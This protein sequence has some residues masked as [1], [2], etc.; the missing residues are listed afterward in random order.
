VGG[1]VPGI[2]TDHGHGAFRDTRRWD[3]FLDED[4]QQRIDGYRQTLSFSGA[5]QTTFEVG[6]DLCTLRVGGSSNGE[7]R[8]IVA[9]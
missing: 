7:H 3:R 1:T 2:G 5:L 6:Q 8:K 4:R 9:K